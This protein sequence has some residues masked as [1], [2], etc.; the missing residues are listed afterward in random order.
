MTF[1]YIS[2]YAN[3]LNNNSQIRRSMDMIYQRGAD[4]LV[5]LTGDTFVSSMELQVQLY[6]DDILVGTMAI[7]PF[8]VSQTGGTYT[9]NFNIRPYDYLSNYIKS[10][11]YQ[12]YYLKFLGLYHTKLILLL[13]YFD[14]LHYCYFLNT[15]EV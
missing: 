10:E 9:Y 2:Q 14:F 11:H 12:T 1:G 6:A 13:V 4:Y 3:G 7:V 8:N 15:K 5:T